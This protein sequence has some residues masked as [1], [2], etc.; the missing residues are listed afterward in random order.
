MSGLHGYAVR[1]VKWIVIN[2]RNRV[3][4]T[5]IIAI[6]V[7][8]AWMPTVGCIVP[9]S[10]GLLAWLA[11]TCETAP[12]QAGSSPDACPASCEYECCAMECT[13]AYDFSQNEQ[14]PVVPARKLYSAASEFQVIVPG[15]VQTIPET[16]QPIFGMAI[17][18]VD[19]DYLY[20]PPG[21]G[22]RSPPA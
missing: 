21:T 6:V 12:V 5:L 17:L 22:S 4:A 18:P 19:T 2:M 11:H 3:A 20:S 16:P 13:C 8:L 7:T 9:A 14:E 10:H 15:F 1:P